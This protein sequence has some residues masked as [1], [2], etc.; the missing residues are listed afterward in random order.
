MPITVNENGVLHELETVTSNEG[1]ILYNLDTVHTNEGGVL[2]EIFSAKTFPKALTWY[3]HSSSYGSVINSGLECTATYVRSAL[4]LCLYFNSTKVGEL[5]HL[6]RGDVVTIEILSTTADISYGYFS[7]KTSAQ[8]YASGSYVDRA[9]GLS[10]LGVGDKLSV[11]A[12]SEGDYN[13]VVNFSTT[14]TVKFRIS[15]K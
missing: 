12:P 9:G 8:D 5:I 11:T 2:Q 4:Y 14:G 3:V 10:K 1:G 13:L 7:L 6:L 15:F